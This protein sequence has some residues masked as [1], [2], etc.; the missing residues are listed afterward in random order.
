[1]TQ[2]PDTSTEAGQKKATNMLLSL[3]GWETSWG[4]A[5][6][7][8]Y[9]VVRDRVGKIMYEGY[10]GLN[11]YNP[12][13]MALA[14]TVLRWALWHDYLLPEQARS[15]IWIKYRIS[16]GVFK[17]IFYQMV[18]MDYAGTLPPSEAMRYWLDKILSLANEA[19]MLE[20][21]Q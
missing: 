10:I 2:L 7:H 18:D 15:V 1:M 9:C 19:G 3:M 14:W 17:T 6:M 12:T 21:L 4:I 11:L 8:G 16:A 20:V 13:H 5:N